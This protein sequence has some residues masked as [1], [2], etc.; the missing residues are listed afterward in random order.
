VPELSRSVSLSSA[1][2][3]DVVSMGSLRP[4]TCS[5]SA[6]PFWMAELSSVLAELSTLEPRWRAE[7]SC[8]FADES[9]SDAAFC[10]AGEYKC[11]IVVGGLG[12]SRT[13]MA[14]LLP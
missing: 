5:G 6:E 8:V 7:P 1:L 2:R 14:S 12:S 11:C 13:E 9:A 10:I 4:K 3:F